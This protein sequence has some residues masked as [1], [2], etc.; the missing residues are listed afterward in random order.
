MFSNTIQGIILCIVFAFCV[1]LIMTHNV[2]VASINVIAIGGVLLTVIGMI[3]MVGWDLGTT[4]SFG[5]DLF[6]GFSV[7]Y[8]VHVGH[9]YVESIYDTRKSRMDHAYK[10]I[11]AA[12]LSGAMTTSISGFFMIP[13]QF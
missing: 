3:Y 1:L 11:G 7:D 10:N 12:V 6:I 4:E 5:I 13:F 9:C 8:I 2:I